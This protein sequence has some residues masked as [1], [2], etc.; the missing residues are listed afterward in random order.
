MVKFTDE[1]REMLKPENVKLILLKHTGEEILAYVLQKGDDDF[2]HHYYLFS[3]VKISGVLNPMTGGMQYLMSEW[4]SNRLTADEGFE[5]LCSDVLVIADV[6]PSMLK[7][8]LGFAEKIETFR[9]RLKQE[10]EEPES[11][12]PNENNDVMIEVPDDGGEEGGE[13]NLD[14]LTPEEEAYMERLAMSVLSPKKQTLH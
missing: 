7:T 6:E 10:P 4:I 2:P 3:P 11:L 9:Q 8:F 12:L 1:H 14:G 5:I 13:D